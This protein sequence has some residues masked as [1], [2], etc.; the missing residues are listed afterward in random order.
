MI[1]L[2]QDLFKPFQRH[3]FKCSHEGEIVSID[4][5]GQKVNLHYNDLFRLIQMMYTHAKLAK[6]ETGDHSRTFNCFAVLG[7]AEE[8][9]K[10]TIPRHI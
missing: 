1:R 4:F 10:A 8:N 5:G 7:T 9:Y 2:L 6:R 3:T